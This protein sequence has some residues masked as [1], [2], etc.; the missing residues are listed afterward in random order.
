MKRS[1]GPCFLFSVVPVLSATLL[2]G[3]CSSSTPSETTTGAG[4]HAGQGSAGVQSSTGGASTPSGSGGA[5]GSP[6]AGGDASAA[7]GGN[8]PVGSGGA[9]AGSTESGADARGESRADASADAAG[10]AKK[11]ASPDATGDTGGAVDPGTDGDGNFMI[12]SPFR[13]AP[14]FTVAAGVPRGRLNMFSLNSTASAIYPSDVGGG[15]AFTRNVWVYVPAQYVAGTAAPFIVVQDGGGFT[16]RIP[17]VL[18]NMINDHRLPVMIAVLINPGPGDGI[19]SERG[20]EY[21]TVSDAYVTFVETE[22]LPEVRSRYNVQLTTDPEGRA[23]LG[24]SSGG[25]A[26]FTMGWFRPDLYHRIVTYSGSFVALGASTTYPHGAWEY[27]EHLI[28]DNALKPLRVFLEAAQN[29]NTVR[30]VPTL[31]DQTLS[32]FFDWLTANQNMAAALRAKGYHYRYIYAA[33]GGHA[34]G[35]VIM[36]TLP[37][38]LLWVWRGYPIR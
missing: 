23:A 6:V 13:A 32:G 9:T 35:N 14:E 38:E 7:T 24:S 1:S 15:G 33:G 28:A 17:P 30:N 8:A 26:A 36:Q 18:D 37:E 12:A 4:G 21:D 3:A 19:G 27:H 10:I 16:T 29:D 34:D 2:A 11:D 20:H 22:I 5:S 25:A 31:R